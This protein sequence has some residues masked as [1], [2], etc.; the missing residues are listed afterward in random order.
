MVSV[1]FEQGTSKVEKGRH[2]TSVET[3]VAT[4]STVLC[5]L[6]EN[7]RVQRRDKFSLTQWKTQNRSKYCLR[8][9]AAHTCLA[10][11]PTVMYFLL[12]CYPGHIF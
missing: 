3:D 10:S 4:G 2:K 1:Q 9:L 5:I 6:T 11:Q 7:M 12:F 8:N